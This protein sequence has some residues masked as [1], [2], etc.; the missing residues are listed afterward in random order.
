MSTGS[1]HDAY[2]TR[3]RLSGAAASDEFARWRELPPRLH[4]VEPAPLPPDV[5][6]LLHRL[7]LRY[8]REAG[9]AVLARARDE[10]WDF[11][12]VLKVLLA[13]EAA[14]RDRSTR[15]MHRK[16]ARLPSGKTF[17]AW[18]PKASAIPGDAQ[19]ARRLDRQGRRADRPLRAGR[20][21]RHRAAARRRRRGR[22]PLSA[23]R[24]RVREALADPDVKPPSGQVRHD[25]PEGPRNGRRRPPPPPCP[26]NRHRGPL[27]SADRGGRGARSSTTRL[28]KTRLAA[29]TPGRRLRRDRAAARAARRPRL[30]CPRRSSQA[31]A[32]L[33][34]L[35]AGHPAHG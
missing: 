22:G 13:E 7:R 32:P 10:G 33:P 28:I 26:R 9:P 24:R 34:R 17:D 4:P 2:E 19:W 12:E 15:E 6:R 3:S 16:A 31:R 5:W 20:R 21:R 25:L 18:D 35:Q 11:T 1:A 8:I 30:W 23:G 27:A 14:G 29:I